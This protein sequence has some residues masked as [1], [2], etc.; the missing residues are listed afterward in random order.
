MTPL[1][2]RRLES[3]DIVEL[4]P[5]HPHGINGSDDLLSYSGMTQLSD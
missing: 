3:A 2:A 4:E 5:H 1:E